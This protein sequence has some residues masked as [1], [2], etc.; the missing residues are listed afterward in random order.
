M[1]NDKYQEAYKLINDN[2]LLKRKSDETLKLITTRMTKYKVADTETLFTLDNK[3][4]NAIE[5]FA[6]LIKQLKLSNIDKKYTYLSEL[7]DIKQK[8]GEY[9]E[10][11]RWYNKEFKSYM[12]ILNS[13]NK[14][15]EEKYKQL[16]NKLETYSFDEYN[17]SNKHMKIIV[18]ANN[19]MIN[20]LKKL[21]K[22]LKNQNYSLY[23][24]LLK[25]MKSV[26]N[27]NQTELIKAIK[28]NGKIENGL[29]ELPII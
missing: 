10:I 18:D 15:S 8:Y 26:I 14:F 21:D 13:I 24:N 28:I 27:E 19:K 12:D 5:N 3:D 22:A 29:N 6:T 9:F 4:W 20:I 11:I 2:N 23:N 7:I 1:Q 16:A 25:D 17:T